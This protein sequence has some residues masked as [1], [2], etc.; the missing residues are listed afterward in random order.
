MVIFA[1]A[2]VALGVR[3]LIGA[4]GALDRPG[5]CS[6]AAGPGS[7]AAGP[8]V[9]HPPPTLFRGNRPTWSNLQDIGMTCYALSQIGR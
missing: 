7:R 4:R 2:R 8:V 1:V 3:L 6:S 5:A 9:H